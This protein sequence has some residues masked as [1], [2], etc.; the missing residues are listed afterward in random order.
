MSIRGA[1][2]YR[3]HRGVVNASGQ[4]QYFQL[5]AV[6]AEADHAIVQPLLTE[7][8]AEWATAVLERA[9]PERTYSQVRLLARPGVTLKEMETFEQLM[10]DELTRL[11]LERQ[12]TPTT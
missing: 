4:V 7:E 9:Y 5:S 6:P 8:R 1:P 2:G 10:V 11:D 3:A 12:Y